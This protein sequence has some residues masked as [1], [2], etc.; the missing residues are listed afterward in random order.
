MRRIVIVQYILMA[1]AWLVAIASWPLRA[2]ELNA[3]LGWHGILD[4]AEFVRFLFRQPWSLHQQPIPIAPSHTL[5]LTLILLGFIF[6]VLS[7]PLTRRHHLW[8]TKG[9]QLIRGFA[10]LLLVLPLTL[11]TPSSWHLPQPLPGMYVLAASHLLMFVA[12]VLAPT[13]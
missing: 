1:I 2:A 3:F 12:I 9:Q 11:W 13:K 6:F 8:P 4:T 7:V 10:I 5:W